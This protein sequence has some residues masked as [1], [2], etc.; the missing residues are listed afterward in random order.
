MK[1]F[2]RYGYEGAS[3]AKLTEAMNINRPSMYA[4][5]GDKESLF[6]KAVDRY[7]ERYAC[8]MEKAIEQPTARDVLR[9]LWQGT[10]DLIAEPSQPRGC[11]L[12]HGALACGSTART[13][14]REMSE[15]RISGE[16]KLAARFDRAV[17]EGDLPKGTDTAALAWYAA[18]V[19]YGLSV[20][21][22]GGAGQDELCAVAAI[23][24][25]CLP[26]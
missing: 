9:V 11:L 1:V 13:V 19:I 10:I 20:R 16:T 3:L 15:R 5:F 23:A 22:A 7:I 6:H 26:S 14:Q 8:Y 25:E 12:V 17:E 2:W 24:M 4:A 21:A 18:T